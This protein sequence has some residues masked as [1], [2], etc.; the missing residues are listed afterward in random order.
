MEN[1]LDRTQLLTEIRTLYASLEGIL[2]SLD[3]AQMTTAGVNG[4]W[5]IKDILAHLTAWHYHLLNLMYAVKHKQ[6]PILN[7]AEDKG[8]NE[9]NAQF[10]EESKPRRLDEVLHSFRETYRQV[11][12][13]LEQM[14]D[15]EL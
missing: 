4:D 3:E 10:R 14:P 7:H 15:D 9:V 11:I 5:S 12:E 1:Q 6:E 8:I 2:S 13:G